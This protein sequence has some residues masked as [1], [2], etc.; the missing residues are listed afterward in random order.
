MAHIDQKKK[1]ILYA[2]E[3][4]YNNEQDSNQTGDTINSQDMEEMR[5]MVSPLL[6]TSTELDGL[7]DSILTGAEEYEAEYVEAL[8]AMEGRNQLCNFKRCT[9]LN[10]S[11]NK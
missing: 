8:E 4:D 11:W 2:Y 1:A 10:Q 9:L 6:E 3:V 7:D 5:K